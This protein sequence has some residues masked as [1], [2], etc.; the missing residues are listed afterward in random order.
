[1]LASWLTE[2]PGSSQWFDQG[3]VT[4]CDRAKHEQLHVP[5]DLLKQM[6]AVSDEVARAMA[7]GAL[8]NSHAH[9]AVGI[10]G[11]AGPEGGSLQ[12]PVGLVYLAWGYREHLHAT[13]TVSSKK[14]LCPPSTRHHVRQLAAREAVK[15]M[16]SLLTPS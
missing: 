5:L 3:W 14:L 1:L 2:W 10:T 12:K 13:L 15:G 16:I 6:G 4:Y 8:L 7:C 11:I 9:V